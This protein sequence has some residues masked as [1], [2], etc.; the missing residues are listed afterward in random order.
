MNGGTDGVGAFH[1]ATGRSLEDGSGAHQRR[2]RA[3]QFELISRHCGPTILEVG[4]GLGEFASQFWGL[5]RH[6]VTDVDPACVASMER[7]FADRPEVETHRYDLQDPTD[8]LGPPVSTVV[9]INVLEHIEDDVTALRS[10][11]RLVEPGGRIVLW[12]PGYMQLYG[13]FDRQVGHVRRYTPDTLRTAIVGAG[14]TPSDVRPVNLLGGI[15]WW[16]AVRRGGVGSPRP[17]LLR[18]Y[19]AVVVP[20]TRAVERRLIPPFGQSILGVATVPAAS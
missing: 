10:L 14:L 2:Y 11:T 8:D 20:I 16:L 12:V 4:A 7:R 15:A 19:D 17:G 3:Y 5:R 1:Q 6:V 13:D 9:A 18:I